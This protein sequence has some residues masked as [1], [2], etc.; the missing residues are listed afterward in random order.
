MEKEKGLE[1]IDAYIAAFPAN[2][3]EKLEKLRAIIRQAE[4]DV[5]EKISYQMP[6]FT[7]YGKNLVHFAA[8]KKH[9]GFYPGASGIANFEEELSAFETSKGT[10]RFPL[11]EPIP[12]DLIGRIVRFRAEENRR[13][14]G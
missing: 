8:F 14:Y 10:V 11:E 12:L 9:I 5:K 7:L 2:V 4:P 3:Q 1:T 6:T 13:K